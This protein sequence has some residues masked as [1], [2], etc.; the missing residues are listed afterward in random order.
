MINLTKGGNINLTKASGPAGLT[1]VIVGVGW[2]PR[3]TDGAQFDL[4]ASAF[5]TGLDGK[6]RDPQDFVFYNNKVGAG[7]SV[8]HG[9]DNRTGQGD[10]DDETI[11]VDLSKVPTV[12][13]KIVFAVT[14]DQ[15]A[16]R[17][18]NFGQV[19]DAYIRVLNADDKVVLT[20]FDL[21]EDTS[22]ETAMIFGELYRADGGDWKFKAIGQGFSGGLAALV[23]HFGL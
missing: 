10:G 1:K 7:G 3:A 17:R 13:A 23:A 8:A 11:A 5:L 22:T 21:S 12:I 2:N 19:S 15:A 16:E 14:I 20:K 4:D 18:Q 9:G 6:C